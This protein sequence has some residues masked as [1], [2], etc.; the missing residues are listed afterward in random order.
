MPNPLIFLASA[1][2]RRSAL[3]RQIGVEH[4]IRPVAVDEARRVHESATAYV[5]RLAETKSRTLWERLPA[6][7]RRPVLGADTTVTLDGE[8]FG[9]PA[10]ADA[11][12]AMLQ[13]LSGR[14][15]EVH[16]A[17]ALLCTG[18]VQLRLSSSAVRFRRLS[19]ADLDWYCASGEPV[20]KAGGYAIQ[21]RAAVFVTHLAGSY[22]GVMGLPLCE[23]WELLAP[24]LAAPDGSVP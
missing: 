4:Q 17:V 18:G 8:I 20:D 9:K 10:D 21:G 15:H 3:L 22:S 1:S 7:E 16:T 12:R 19:D 14:T 24:V 13:L 5:L 23:T 11:A 2:P 6:A